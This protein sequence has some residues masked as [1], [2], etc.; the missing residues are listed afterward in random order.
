MSTA[1][2]GLAA[3]LGDIAQTANEISHNGQRLSDYALDIRKVSPGKQQPRQIFDDEK[4]TD[5]VDSITKNGVLQPIVV[6]KDGD[7]HYEIIAGERR[8]R[9]SMKAGLSEIPAIIIECSDTEALQ[10]GLIENLQRDDLNPMDEAEAYVRLAHDYGKTQEEIAKAVSKSR[11]Y[12]ANQIRLTTLPSTVRE[13]IRERKLSPGHARN[14]VNN[15]NAEHM[16]HQIIAEGMNVRATEALRQQKKNPMT[17]N[18]VP[19][20]ANLIEPSAMSEDIAALAKR[21]QDILHMKVKI[22]ASAT[23]GSVT[24]SFYS[25]DQLDDLIQ[26]LDR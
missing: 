10:I 23:G 12:V 14:L 11:S 3:L 25:Y 1:A 4:L 16:A 17:K 26:R 5:L 24:I 19:I 2:K 20:K 7:D 18:V 21:L 9:A 22:S 6:R 13:M 8:Y 15:P